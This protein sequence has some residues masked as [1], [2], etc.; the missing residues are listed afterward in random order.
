MNSQRN[1]PASSDVSILS[2]YRHTSAML[3]AGDTRTRLDVCFHS[4]DQRL[5][6]DRCE[7][8]IRQRVPFA[9]VFLTERMSQHILPFVG[10][11]S[12]SSLDPKIGCL[13][14][15]SDMNEVFDVRVVFHKIGNKLVDILIHYNNGV[16]IHVYSDVT[17]LQV[18]HMIDKQLDDEGRWVC[19]NFFE[20]LHVKLVS[21]IADKVCVR[22]N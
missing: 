15:N 19:Y 13:L 22:N 6:V 3:T 4:F 2:I 18:L 20:R 21:D 14:V 1:S 5:G 8:L 9:I 7:E 12:C 10:T 11:V 17:V 16:R